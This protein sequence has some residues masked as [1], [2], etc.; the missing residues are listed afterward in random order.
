MKRLL[1][2]L[3]LSVSTFFVIQSLLG[4]TTLISPTGDGGF[5]TGSTFAANSW[6]VVNHTTNTW[7]VGTAATAYAGARGA[8]V[9]N[10]GGTTWAYTTTVSQ[11]SHFYRDIAVPAGESVINLSF[12]WKGNGESS[13]DRLLV[14]TAPTSVTPVAGTPASNSTT[15]TGATLVYTQASNAQSSYTQANVTLAGSLAGT[16]FRLI[17][18]WQNDSSGGTSPGAAIDNIG[19]T[20]AIPPP[21]PANDNCANAT[22]LTV[23]NDYNCGSTTNGTTISAT[24][25]SETAPSCSATGVDDDVWYS[26][27]STG[28]QHQVKISGATNTTA[29]AIYSGACGS[30]IQITGACAS[31]TSGTATLNLTGLT[32]LTNYYVRVYTTSTGVASNFTMCIG[33]PPPPPPNDDPCGAIS[34]TIAGTCA[35]TQYTTESATASPGI[36]APGCAGSVFIDV[37]FKFVVPSSGAIIINTNTGVITDSGMAIYS[38]SDNTCNGTLTLIECDDDDSPNGTMSFISR[39]GLTPGATIFIRFWEYGGDNN[40]TFNICVADVA[41]NDECVGAKTLSVSLSTTCTTLLTGENTI[42]STS[43]GTACSGIADDDLWYSFVATMSTHIV[44]ISNVTPSTTMITQAYSGTCASLTQIACNSTTNVTN[45][46]GLTPNSTYY[47]RIHTSSASGTYA[48]YDLC[49]TQAPDM[50]FTSCTVGAQ[51]TSSVGAGAVDANIVRLDV[52]VTG[53]NNPL[54]ATSFTCNTNGSTIPVTNN[55]STA[56]V[57][58]TGTSSTFTTT[59]LVGSVAIAADGSFTITGTQTLTGGTSNTTNYFWLAYD[60]LCTATNAQVLDGEFNSVTI[61]GT[62]Q[63][64]TAQ[65]ISGT[66][67]ITALAS[68]DTNADGN[69]SSAGTWKCGIP[70][71]PCTIPINVNHNVVLNVDHVQNANF[72]LAAS[73]TL[74]I[75]TNT[76]TINPTTA[77]VTSTFNG[78]VNVSGSGTLTTGSS[79]PSTYTANATVASTGS[80]N[81]SGGTVN[82]GTAV[83]TNSS[84]LTV[85][86]AMT[87]SG[88]GTFNAGPAN[89]YTRLTSINGSLNMSGGTFEQNGTLTFGSSS[90]WTMNGGILNIDPNGGTSATSAS[91]SGALYMQSPTINVT[92]GTINFKDPMY[93]STA[94]SARTIS[95]STTGLDVAIG[96]GC[97]INIGTN[98]GGNHSN[99]G[100]NG[101]YIECNT[102]TGTIELGTVI[103]NG[104]L[105]TATNSRHAST[106]TSSGY[107]TKI[108]NLTVNSGSEFVVNSTVLAVT[109]NVVNNGLMTVTSATVDNGLAFVGD[110]Q[111]SGGVILS[112]GSN[113][114]SLSGTGFFRKATADPV[115]GSQSGN[116]CSA[117]SVWQTAG[118]AGVTLNMPLTITAAL[119]LNGGQTITS[120]S[121]FM[122]LG[123]SGTLLGTL[124]TN[125]STAP[126]NIQNANVGGWVNGPFKRWFSG[127]TTDAS[128][129]GILPVGSSTVPQYAQVVFTT[130][131]G[132]GTLTSYFTGGAPGDTGLPLTD[133]TGTDPYCN[134][135]AV[136]STGFVTITPG[137]GLGTGTYT[138]RFN[139]TNYSGI[140][141]LATARVL[142]RPTGGGN[143]T[144]DGTYVAGA[145]NLISRTGMSGFSEFAAV[146]GSNISLPLE[147]LSFKGY[148]DKTVNVLE[149][150]TATEI[151]TDKF[152]IERSADGENWSEIASAKAVGNSLSKHVY[153]I[154]DPQPYAKSYYRLITVD[155][156]GKTQ[157]SHVIVIERSRKGFT[158]NSVSPNPNNGNFAVT[159]N[160]IG[161]GKTNLVVVNSLGLKVYSKSVDTKAGTN[162]EFLGIDNLTDGIYTLILEQNGQIVTQRIAIN[163]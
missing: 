104:G 86:G 91:S 138:S 137:D 37:W 48:I 41:S 55:I 53:L 126:T 66:R 18:T 74:T 116:L 56:K 69:W 144:L 46:T 45:L 1:L 158:I 60:L 112:N 17:F 149:W 29:I 121:N 10:D 161:S 152:I 90:S 50:T 114:Q 71:N 39:K 127:N 101:F 26:F 8:Y 49:I 111:Y 70:P 11:T 162:N 79:L 80:L 9:S 110:A 118:G 51:N 145:N 19:L 75:S 82:I 131:P 30:L 120:S 115:P 98:T 92:G 97:T 107:I 150:A 72:T 124:Y 106:Y 156:D 143:W 125:S 59:T 119:R 129:Q 109:G 54:S 95:Y 47:L 16:T 33:T 123:T 83:S 153:S 130:T 28:T 31:T 87:L 4:Q 99:S 85:S 102:S 25:S 36:P 94:S 77:T 93:S 13:W 122:A 22:A 117:F 64:P 146:Q 12:Y 35:F 61:G 43:S 88:T 148:A 7:Q 34:I 38:S 68:Y 163:K 160:S 133:G 21:P 78:T 20:S 89:G 65:N 57:Y 132:S 147:L 14:Y 52:T 2:S 100:S 108:K 23:N 73:K 67:S 40:G 5:E 128:Q 141:T 135:G 42:Y 157:L 81:I 103:V 154:N 96:T 105:Y 84:N 142:K 139:V 3:I 159:F 136:S 63:V 15:L 62:P 76:L 58:Y 32:S 27:V 140:T 6:T 44:T 24:Q 155:M 151:N 134:P 113:A